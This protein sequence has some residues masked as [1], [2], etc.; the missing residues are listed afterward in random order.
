MR[1][2]TETPAPGIGF[3]PGSTPRPS[4]GHLALRRYRVSLSDRAYFITACSHERQPF[5]EQQDIASLL[6]DHLRALE[7]AAQIELIASVVMSNHVHVV[8]TLQDDATIGTVMKL[9]R[10]ASAQSVNRKL[11]RSGSVWERGYFEH[12]IRTGES[13]EPVLHYMWHNP[14]PPGEHFRCRR[15]VWEWFRACVRDEPKYYDWLKQNP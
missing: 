1:G 10:G 3:A 2:E 15:D 12:L 4:R 6:F 9:F 7:G 5:F 11:G 14:T 13:L 8:F